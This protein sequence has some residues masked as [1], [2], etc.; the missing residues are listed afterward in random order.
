MAI[1]MLRMPPCCQ[2]IITNIIPESQAAKQPVN[3]R[4]VSC[5]PATTLLR[6]PNELAIGKV[7]GTPTLSSTL[8]ASN[9][10][11]GKKE[12]ARIIRALL[13]AQATGRS[14]DAPPWLRPL[15]RQSHR[16][17]QL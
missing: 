12:Q 5:S 8:A 9:P 17:F 3:I 15:R 6:E 16:I 7:Q 1:F 11:N 2:A 14:S 13:F 10:L 4:P